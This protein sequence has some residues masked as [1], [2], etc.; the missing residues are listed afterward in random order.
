MPAVIVPGDELEIDRAHAAVAIFDLEANIGKDKAIAFNVQTMRI[1]HDLMRA[2]TVAMCVGVMQRM[3]CIRLQLVVEHHALNRRTLS[4][5]FCFNLAHHPEEARVVPDLRGFDPTAVV[6]LTTVVIGIAMMIEQR[7]ALP[8]DADNVGDPTIAH[9]R[10][11]ALSNQALLFQ[12]AQILIET[13]VMCVMFQVVG[14]RDAVLR[15]AF[16][17]IHFRATQVIHAAAVWDRLALA[18]VWQCEAMFSAVALIAP[19]SRRDPIGQ[20]RDPQLGLVP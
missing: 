6:P 13:I 3:K 14:E 8:R 16:E 10:D 7:L 9:M 5:E 11:A 1:G 2:F 19:R 4:S 12:R 17:Q 18:P 20:R 15:G